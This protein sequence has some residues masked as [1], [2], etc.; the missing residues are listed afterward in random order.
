MSSVKRRRCFF[1]MTIDGLLAGR[2]VFE[3]YDDLTPE[4]AE[5]FV[6]L[7]AG[8]SGLGQTTG[9]QLT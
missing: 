4:T 7:C 9:K 1:D 3:V 6:Q 5:N 8:Q 2:I